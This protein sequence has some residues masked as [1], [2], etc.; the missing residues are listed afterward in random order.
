MIYSFSVP[1]FADA[2]IPTGPID[3]TN[4]IFLL[5]RAPSPPSSL[6][7]CRNGIILRAGVGGDYI[8][9]DETIEFASGCQPVPGDIL[10]SW[11]RY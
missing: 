11:Y 6:Q 8:L 7:L 9:T 10:Q 5:Q 4:A 1:E 3:G 2:E